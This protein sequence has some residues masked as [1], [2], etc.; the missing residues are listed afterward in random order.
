M[1]RQNSKNTQ[2]ANES[3]FETW[4]LSLEFSEATIFFYI[5][6]SKEFREMIFLSRNITIAICMYSEGTDQQHL[7]V[8][9]KANLSQ[10]QFKFW[11]DKKWPVEG[12]ILS[13]I[14]IF[15]S[16]LSFELSKLFNIFLKVCI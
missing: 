1:T 4:K 3:S 6:H 5:H 2:D 16:S 9:F 10:V 8:Q 14:S 11:G 12:F 7:H 15:V 13:W